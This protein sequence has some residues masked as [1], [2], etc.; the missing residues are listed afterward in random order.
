MDEFYPRV[1]TVQNQDIKQWIVPTFPHSQSI[2]KGA[3]SDILVADEPVTDASIEWR[4]EAIQRF[5][6]VTGP[7]NQGLTKNRQVEVDC[8][9][10][11]IDRGVKSESPNKHTSMDH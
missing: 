2:R 1:K 7:T 3:P 11:R 8:A 6:R 10:H 5:R 9:F 4:L